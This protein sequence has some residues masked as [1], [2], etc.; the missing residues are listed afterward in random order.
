MQ[1]VYLFENIK[2]NNYTAFLLFRLGFLSLLQERTS[3][4]FLLSLSPVLSTN[5]NKKLSSRLQQ[6]FINSLSTVLQ[7]IA[8]LLKT[9]YTAAVYQ[10]RQKFELHVFTFMVLRTLNV[11]QNNDFFTNV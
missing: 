4:M 5:A 3:A 11:S 6:R 2:Q 9:V 1:A 10:V 8:H 7:K